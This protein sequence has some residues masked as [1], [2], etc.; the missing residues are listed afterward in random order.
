[1]TVLLA[2]AFAAGCA[3]IGGETI[4]VS[5]LNAGAPTVVSHTMSG[6][7]YRTFTVSATE[8]KV[9][10]LSALGRMGF[11]VKAMRSEKD[12]DVIEA[13]TQERRIEIGVE[14]ISAKATRLRV[15]A[16]AGMFSYDTATAAEIVVQT[17]KSINAREAVTA[18]RS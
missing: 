7:A 1:V 16:K 11:E 8:V 17:E 15:V 6:T 10:A 9:A 4:A 18:Q 13:E 3:L 12:G 5:A 14:A 2:P